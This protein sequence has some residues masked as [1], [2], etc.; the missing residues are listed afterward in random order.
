VAD[1]PQPAKPFPVVK[2]AGVM[3]VVVGGLAALS[4]LTMRLVG[5]DLKVYLE[6]AAAAIF[7]GGVGVLAL[8]PIAFLERLQ[9]P[10]GVIFGFLMGTLLRLLLTALAAAYAVMSLDSKRL[11]LWLILWYLVVLIVEVNAVTSHLVM[12]ALK[13]NTDKPEPAPDIAGKTTADKP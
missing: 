13:S 5:L 9:G 1:L 7:C 6:C 3:V 12:A 8:A 11:A 2:T 4:I 10:V